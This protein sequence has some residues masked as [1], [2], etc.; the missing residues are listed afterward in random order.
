VYPGPQ[1]TAAKGRGPGT[2]FGNIYFR[3]SWFCGRHGRT[4][5]A[6]TSRNES[7]V[8]RISHSTGCLAAASSSKR[9]QGTMRPVCVLRL[10][11]DQAG[12]QAPESGPRPGRCTGEWYAQLARSTRKKTGLIQA[13]RPCTKIRSMPRFGPAAQVGQVR[14]RRLSPGPGEP[15][16]TKVGDFLSL[17]TRV[18]RLRPAR[19]LR[20]KVHRGDNNRGQVGTEEWARQREREEMP[21]SGNVGRNDLEIVRLYWKQMR[22]DMKL[23]YSVADSGPFASD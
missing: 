9:H 10:F 21:L 18:W 23:S 3:A 7:R 19:F 11:P 4:L 5:A 6:A 2:R 8:F 13:L 20:P 1:G 17:F 12:P 14:R 22:R 16:R 15:G